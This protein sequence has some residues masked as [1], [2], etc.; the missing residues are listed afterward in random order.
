[1]RIRTRWG[2]LML[3]VLAALGLTVGTGVKPAFAQDEVCGNSGQG[4]CLNDWG[5]QGADGD[6]VKMYYGGSDNEGF[7]WQVIDRCNSRGTVTATCPLNDHALDA[8]LYNHGVNPAETEQL[9]YFGTQCLATIPVGASNAGKAILGECN[10]AATGSGGSA[11]TVF[12]TSSTAEWDISNYWSNQDF[13]V[14]CLM[15]GGN[16]GVQAYY[17]GGVSFSW[18]LPNCTQWVPWG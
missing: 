16:P 7:T 11:G 6:A 10:N 15:S 17:S 12:I 2:V 3:A 4:Y 8:T 13:A 5:G 1:M 14:S 9:R 18:T